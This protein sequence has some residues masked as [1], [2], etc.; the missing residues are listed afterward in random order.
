VQFATHTT[1]STFQESQSESGAEGAQSTSNYR[2]QMG[3]FSNEN[4]GMIV[5]GAFALFLLIM[6]RRA[7]KRS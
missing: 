3:D 6:I 7:F 5:M 2:Q 1:L 4:W